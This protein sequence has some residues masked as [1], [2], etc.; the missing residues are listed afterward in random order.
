MPEIFPRFVDDEDAKELTEWV[1]LGELEAIIRGFQKDKSPGPNDWSIK[2][3]LAFFDLLGQDLLKVINHCS[4]TGKTP[5]ATK[6]TF[7]ALIPKSDKPASFNDFR[8]ISLCNCLYKIMA[9]ILVNR[10]KPILSA[11]ISPEQFTFLQHRHIHEAIGTTQELLHSMKSK[12]L[13]GMILKVD[14]SKAFDRASLLYIRMLLTHLGFPY[15]FIKRVMS[16]ISYASYSVLLNGS[17]TPFF[18]AERGLKQGCPLSPLLFLLIMEGLSRLI[19]TEHRRG[20]ITR[21]K[22]TENCSLTHLLFVDDVLIFLNGS[23]ANTSSLHL[24]FDLS[25][26]ATGMIINVHKSTL[27]AIGCSQHEV[28]Y[29]RHRFPFPSHPMEEGMKYLGFRVNHGGYKIVD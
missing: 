26:K 4:L 27:I 15:M 28:F 17:P 16:C 19:G 22:I 21:I 7:I 6:A 12:N 20:R 23:L 18:T 1:S 11:H 10:L 9:K 2:F 25:Q 5:S 3:Y 29:N 14:L 13:K 24:A 8:P